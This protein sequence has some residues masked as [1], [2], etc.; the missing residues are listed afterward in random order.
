MESAEIGKTVKINKIKVKDDYVIIEYNVS[1][2]KVAKLKVLYQAYE[3]NY[4]YEGVIS[5]ET[6][7][8]LIVDN[9]KYQIKAYVTNLMIKKPYSK[10][11]IIYKCN[12]KFPNNVDLIYE[13]CDELEEKRIIDDKE[14]VQT[15]LEYFN[16]SLYGKYYIINYFKNKGIDEEYINQIN[17]LDKSECEKAKKYF[18]LIKNKYVSSNYIKQ[19]KKLSETMLVKG[20]DIEVINEVLSSLK[21][22]P[23]IEKENF[24]KE[25]TKAKEKFKDD[26]EKENRIISYMVNRG[27]SYNDV[28]SYLDKE[29]E[30]ANKND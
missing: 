21:I 30:G 12:E 23:N 15:F 25:L 19:K 5:E 1:E 2:N 13:V 28:S 11:E 7:K 16:S 4:F 9:A 20:F 22:D 14:Y 24:L 3:D 27:Y 29:K 26:K 10:N 6:F 18:E 17:F 8:R